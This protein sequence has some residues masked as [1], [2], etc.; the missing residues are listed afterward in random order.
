M[1]LY[2]KIKNAENLRIYIFALILISVFIL[3]A[4]GFFPG[5]YL[6][7]NEIYNEFHNYSSSLSKFE[8]D[9]DVF[10]AESLELSSENMGSVKLTIGNKWLVVYPKKYFSGEESEGNR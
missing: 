10:Y 8:I 6:S 3:F 1:K 4:V 5:C 7:K 9:G 2:S